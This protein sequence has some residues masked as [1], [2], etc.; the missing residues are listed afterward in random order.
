MPLHI[1]W[2]QTADLL[3][4]RRHVTQLLC[5]NGQGTGA[6]LSGQPPFCV[7][8]IRLWR[9]CLPSYLPRPHHAWHMVA[10]L[11]IAKHTADKEAG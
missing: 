6:R 11:A 9:L 7:S 8:H 4:R 5:E 1:H 10:W 2:N 3:P